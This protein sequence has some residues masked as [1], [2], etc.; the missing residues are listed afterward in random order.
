MGKK[1][2][3]SRSGSSSYSYSSSD[4]ESDEKK[5]RDKSTDRRTPAAADLPPPRHSDDVSDDVG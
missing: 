5:P 3:E 2:S 4:S 1:E